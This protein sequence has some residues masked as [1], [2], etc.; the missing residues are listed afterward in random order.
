[1]EQMITKGETVAFT[2]DHSVT[3]G[4]R[5]VTTS[6]G[7]GHSRVGRRGARGGRGP[8]AP[9]G[10][11]ARA[12]APTGLRKGAWGAESVRARRALRQRHL[13]LAAPETGLV[14]RGA[15]PDP[16]PAA[17]GRRPRGLPEPMVRA[18][19]PGAPPHCPRSARPPL[20]PPRPPARP[21]APTTSVRLPA[22][23]PHGARGSGA[24]GKSGGPSRMP[25]LATRAGTGAKAPRQPGGETGLARPRPR[26]RGLGVPRTLTL[27]SCS[28]TA[29]SS[30]PRS[31][32]TDREPEVTAT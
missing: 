3:W 29:S 6:Q 30:L 17:R 8:E 2:W 14:R 9:L 12:G 19:P 27:R 20:A 24:R 22:P 5:E 18:P 31:F 28:P 26:G 23:P 21:S 25:F 15:P 4:G 13:I 32:G 11:A 16:H 1:M 7:A 10:P